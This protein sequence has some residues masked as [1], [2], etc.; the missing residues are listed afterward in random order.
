MGAALLALPAAAIYAYA[1]F[2]AGFSFLGPPS[3]PE[4]GVLLLVY[5]VSPAFLGLAHVL[6]SRGLGASWSRSL[7]VA[8]P[9]LLGILLLTFATVGPNGGPSRVLVVSA[10][11]VAP[12]L[13]TLAVS[14]AAGVGGAGMLAVALVGGALAVVLSSASSFGALL[15]GLVVGLAGWVIL[16]LVAVSLRPRS[17]GADSGGT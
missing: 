16:P 10:V 8:A 6:L 14:P 7:A 5:A 11:V 17:G 1:A 13:T 4:P 12:V 2:A 15:V 3:P 9:V